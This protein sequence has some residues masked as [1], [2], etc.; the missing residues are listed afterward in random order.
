MARKMSLSPTTSKEEKN[1]IDLLSGEDEGKAWIWVLSIMF[2]Q[3]PG[4]WADREPGMLQYMG[5]RMTQLSN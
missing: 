3:A 1:P 4:V 5:H 2:K